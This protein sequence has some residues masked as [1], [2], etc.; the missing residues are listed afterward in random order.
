MP[1]FLR[2]T[3]T[4]L[5]GILLCVVLLGVGSVVIE[6]YFRT[7]LPSASTAVVSALVPAMLAG[8]TFVG[9]IGQRP[10]PRDLWGFSLWFAIIQFAIA[11]AF[12]AAIGFFGSEDFAGMAGAENFMTIALVAMAA[13]FAMTV[14]VSRAGLGM[15]VKSG[16]K[17]L[18]R[19]SQR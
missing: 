6:T 8:M 12:L 5:G 3:M 7:R 11:A 2:V 1:Y 18:E 16:L 9:R 14:L 19:A 4:Y 15:G 17:A 10:H 13:I